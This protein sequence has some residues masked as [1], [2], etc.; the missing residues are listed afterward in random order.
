MSVTNEEGEMSEDPAYQ[1][2]WRRKQLLA[3]RPPRF[4]RTRWWKT[5]GLSQIEHIYFEAIQRSSSLL[6][7]GAGDGRVQRKF[8]AA[9]FRGEYHTLDVGTEHQHTYRD[10]SQVLRKYDA[11]LCLDVIEH[12]PLR[13]GLGLLQKL[14]SLLTPGGVLILQTPNARCIAN[15]MAWDMTHVQIYNAGDLWAYLTC[16][17][18]VT[19]GYRVAF[20]SERPSLR[21]RARALLGRFIVTR[22]LGLDDTANIAILARKPASGAVA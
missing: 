1:N 19:E 10:L 4:P 18:M 20:T 3:E 14:C 9:G 16:L 13:D 22:L 2:Y 6:D 7:F 15:P 11:V 8:A 21:D 5:E 12:M 17:G